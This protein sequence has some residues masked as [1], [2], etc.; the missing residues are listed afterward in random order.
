MG[1]LNETELVNENLDFYI[2]KALPVL[3]TGSYLLKLIKYLLSDI[4]PDAQKWV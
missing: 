3:Q 4:L 2:P 1:K